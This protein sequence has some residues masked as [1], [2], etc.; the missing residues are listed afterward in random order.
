MGMSV[1]IFLGICTLFALVSPA[2]AQSS[3]V[4]SSS[5]VLTALIAE[6]SAGSS[7]F[8]G[9]VEAIEQSDG[10]VFVEEGKC[11]KGVPACLKWQLTLAGANR[12]LFVLIATGRPSLDVMA[13]VGHELRHALEVLDDRS[14]RSSAALLLFYLGNRGG[15]GATRA[16][17][18]DAAVEAGHDVWH[19]L[20]RTPPRVVQ[21]A[22][23]V[24]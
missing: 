4:R 14:I 2:G 16:I 6:A 10:I 1:R 3:G 11:S 21:V 12:I 15:N 18:T 5:P 9:M 7:T 24:P 13:S 8:R 22:Q 20:R 17:E 19:E 23:V